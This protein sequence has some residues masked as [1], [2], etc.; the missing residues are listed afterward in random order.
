MSFSPCNIL[1][2]TSLFPHRETKPL[3][4]RFKGNE[5]KSFRTLEEAEAYLRQ[6]DAPD[7][8]VGHLSDEN[9][10]HNEGDKST[11]CAGK[12][13]VRP[14]ALHPPGRSGDHVAHGNWDLTAE[15]GEGGP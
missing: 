11:W 8:T 14:D 15:G 12:G 9:N 13:G 10:S 4:N 3:V 1:A 2:L 5:H 7:Y 6:D